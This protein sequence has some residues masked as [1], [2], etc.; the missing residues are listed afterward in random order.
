MNAGRTHDAPRRK[1][2]GG[3]RLCYIVEKR[4][5]R[6]SA[7]NGGIPYKIWRSDRI[8]IRTLKLVKGNGF[9]SHILKI[10]SYNLG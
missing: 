4:K 7:G 10:F 3:A 9:R 2:C 6:D 8:K 5:K 1:F